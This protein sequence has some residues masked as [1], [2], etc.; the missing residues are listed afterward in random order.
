MARILTYQPKG[1][2]PA[3]C[4]R[5]AC[6]RLANVLCEDCVEIVCMF[7]Y[8][9]F[10]HCYKSGHGIYQAAVMCETRKCKLASSG[11]LWRLTALKFYTVTSWRRGSCISPTR[12]QKMRSRRQERLAGRITSML[13]LRMTDY[14]ITSLGRV[15]TDMRIRRMNRLDRPGAC[16]SLPPCAAFSFSRCAPIFGVLL[17]L[18]SERIC[19]M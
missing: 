14:H 17:F 12:E 3:S 11:S 13:W 7:C 1:T 5:A 18:I 15:G 2:A 10:F 16:L 8:P 9:V 19:F 6:S 4:M